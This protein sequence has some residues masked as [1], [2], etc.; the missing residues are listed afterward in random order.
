M[1]PNRPGSAA[2]PS[3]VI[4]RSLLAG[5]LSI[6]VRISD[7]KFTQI[8]MNSKPKKVFTGVSLD[9]PVAEYLDDLSNRMGMSRSRVLNTVVYEYAKMMEGVDIA[10]WRIDSS[11]SKEIISRMT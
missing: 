7:K 11:R 4:H 10:P 5:S 3:S 1:A 6:R 2:L 8:R 9:A